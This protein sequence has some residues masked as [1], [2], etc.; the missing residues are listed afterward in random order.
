MRVIRRL[1]LLMAA[2]VVI[3]SV[4]AVAQEQV[5][6]LAGRW[7]GAVKADI[8][9]MPI[10]A[11]FKIEGEKFTG[12][13]KTFHGAFKIGK[14]EREKDGRWKLSFTTEDGAAGSMTGTLNAD[15]FAGDWDFR[16]NAIGKFTL[17]K[18]K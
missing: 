14:A 1:S 16:P 10:E 15:T 17:T 2:W 9:E 12:E 8:G 11:V 13:I 3:G 4:P 5:G 7:I 18:V 6:V